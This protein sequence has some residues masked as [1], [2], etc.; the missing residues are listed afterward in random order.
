MIKSK[1]VSESSDD[2]Q[3]VTRSH[4][5]E[6]SL[7]QGGSSFLQCDTSGVTERFDVC[8]SKITICYVL[9][10]YYT[11]IPLYFLPAVATRNLNTKHNNSCGY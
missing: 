10:E 6:V 9:K 4:A 2:D 3:L 7:R 5:A 8:A 1:F 11:V